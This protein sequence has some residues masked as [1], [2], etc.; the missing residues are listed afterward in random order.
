MGGKLPRKFPRLDRKVTP[1][2][3]IIHIFKEF[4]LSLFTGL[5]LSNVANNFFPS[6]LSW[7]MKK[8]KHNGCLYFNC[9]FSFNIISYPV[10]Q[11][12]NFVH[13][14]LR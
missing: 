9:M 5:E 1:K 10:L 7:V 2:V 6:T 4:H 11:R 13:A 8:K 3:H 12:N 14:I